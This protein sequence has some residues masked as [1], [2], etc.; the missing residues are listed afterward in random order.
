[1]NIASIVND[2]Y[3]AGASNFL[4]WNVP[5]LGLAPV[6]QGSD[7]NSIAAGTAIV[8]TMNA[9]L[10]AALSPLDAL[11]I[12]IFRFDAFDFSQALVGDPQA[13]GFVDASFP[14]AVSP[15]C[16]D[17]PTGFF[18]WDGIHPT[19]AGHNA[20][21][22]A[23]LQAIPQAVSGPGGLGLT[24]LGLLAIAWFV[25]RQPRQTPRAVHTVKSIRRQRCVT[26]TKPYEEIGGWGGSSRRGCMV[27]ASRR[28]AKSSCGSAAAPSCRQLHRVPSRQRA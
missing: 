14:C 8:R 24:A 22:Q 12:D 6:L 20:I 23:A 11:P 21:A 10:A 4:I 9:L 19:T 5:D 13:S 3:L 18:F 2:L 15:T 1:M 27:S 28:R 26:P 7:P 25:G 16:I 17:D